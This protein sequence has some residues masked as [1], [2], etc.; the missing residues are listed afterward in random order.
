[1]S[2]VFQ[3]QPQTDWGRLAQAITAATNTLPIKSGIYAIRNKIT[4][5]LYVGST[6]GLQ[7]NIPQ[8]ARQ[9]LSERAIRQFRG[10]KQSSEHVRKRMDSK[11]RTL[12]ARREKRN[13]L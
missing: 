3:K 4:G 10:S 13:A 9:K 6:K 11:K 7:Y 5:N 2:T 12:S 1:M 8:E